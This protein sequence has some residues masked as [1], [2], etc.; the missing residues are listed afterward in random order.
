[1]VAT[2]KVKHVNKNKLTV[3]AVINNVNFTTPYIQP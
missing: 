2:I 1:M 3:N